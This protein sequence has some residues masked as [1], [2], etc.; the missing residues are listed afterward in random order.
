MFD[1]YNEEVINLRREFHKIPELGYFEFKTKAK[2]IDYLKSIGIE[3]IKEISDT[4]ICATIFGNGKKTIG[5]RADIDALPVKEETELPFSSLHD[6]VMHACGHD[7]HIAIALT[8]AKFFKENS[9]LLKG[10]LKLIF[11][12]AEEGEGG[13][14]MMIENKVLEN[15]KVDCMLSCHLWPDIETGKADASHGTTFASDTLIEIE[16]IGKGGHGAY[17]EKIKDV[18]YAGSEIII[19]LKKLSKDFNDKGVKNVLSMCSF[20]CAST[21]NVFKDSAHLKGTLR[22]IDEQSEIV[23]SES[24]RN[25]VKKILDDNNID[26]IINVNLN[27]IPLVNDYGVTNAVRDVICDTLGEENLYELGYAMTAEDFA[28]FA[29][30]VKSCHIK[31]GTKSEDCPYPLHSAKYTINEDSLL[32]GV[33]ILAN[34]VI[35]LLGD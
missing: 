24:I 16:I 32:V 34:S 20:D 25:T 31:V 13:A 28:Y 27:Y 14:K 10:N 23:V 1:K 6:G 3:D 29:K 8:L 15:P 35:K 30:E 7:G 33:K 22:M 11:Q 21:H 26:G 19:A 4:G 5:I 17:P 18:I 12:P 9:H 2:I